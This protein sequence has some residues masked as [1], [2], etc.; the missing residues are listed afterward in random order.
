[1]SKMEQM[2]MYIHTHNTATKC[3]RQRK[4]LHM[5]VSVRSEQKGMRGTTESNEV[6]DM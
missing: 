2:K 1:M 3:Y 5:H 6:Q 4:D